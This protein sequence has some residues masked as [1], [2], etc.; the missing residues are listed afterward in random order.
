MNDE[1]LKTRNSLMIITIVLGLISFIVGL[2]FVVNIMSWALGIAIGIAVCVFRV[3]SITRQLE[4]TA[5][6][7]PE[8]A[9]NYARAKYMMRYLI[10]FVVAAF[11]CYKGIANPVG[12]I[13]GLLLLQPAVYIYNFMGKKAD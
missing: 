8:N 3:F 4:R 2:F 9:Q 12:V 1:V 7:T 13:V 5:D 11:V 10:T 6:M